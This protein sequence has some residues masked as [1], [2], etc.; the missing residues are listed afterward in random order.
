MQPAEDSA[1]GEPVSS[2]CKLYKLDGKS[3]EAVGVGHAWVNTTDGQPGG[4]L[5]LVDEDDTRRLLVSQTVEATSQEYLRQ[6]DVILFTHQTTQDEYGLSFEDPAGCTSVWNQLC[7][8]RGIATEEPAESPHVAEVTRLLGEGA[9]PP[10]ERGHLQ[11]LAEF[12]ENQFT[13]PVRDAI[14]GY[15]KGQGYLELLLELFDESETLEDIGNLHCIWRILRS[16]VLLNSN[17]LLSEMV[18]PASILRVIACFE[19]NPLRPNKRLN[20]RKFLSSV[21]FLNPAGLSGP[22]CERIRTIYL[23]QYLKDTVLAAVLDEPSFESIN[24]MVILLRNEALRV[25]ARSCTKDGVLNHI[26]TTIRD[27]AAEAEV[28]TQLLCFLDEIINAARWL[29]PQHRQGFLEHLIREA[30]IL[31]I[32]ALYIRDDSEKVR[33]AAAG[34]CRNIAVF[35]VNQVRQFSLAEAEA[36][37]PC[38]FLRMLFEQ[39]VHEE[40]EGL[41]HQ[42]ADVVRLIV[43]TQQQKQ[44][45]AQQVDPS[46]PEM[47]PE[48][49]RLLYEP[50]PPDDPKLPVIMD[51][52]FRPI[53]FHPLHAAV[54]DVPEIHRWIH[55]DPGRLARTLFCVMPVITSCL[56]G[57]KRM[58]SY[59]LQRHIPEKVVRILGSDKAAVSRDRLTVLWFVKSMVSV[60]N[61]V[62][63][64]YIA[65]QD[66]FSVVF[67]TLEHSSARA[68]CDLPASTCLSM[69]KEVWKDNEQTLLKYLAEK[70]SGLLLDQRCMFGTEVGEMIMKKHEANATRLRHV[71]ALA[72]WQAFVPKLKEKDDPY[73]DEPLSPGTKGYDEQVE[74]LTAQGQ[75]RPR[76]EGPDDPEPGTPK[77]ARIPDPIDTPSQPSADAEGD[78]PM[79]DGSA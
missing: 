51:T 7:V 11:R 72:D 79:A 25:I 27:F 26:F 75:K 5:M 16:M 46:I 3:W 73:F 23:L 49:L 20:H 31:R 69:L 17:E 62:L 57:H 64:R 52:L 19:Y 43:E 58:G 63:S 15:F 6:D 76:E 71:A 14:A 18:Q 60:H 45:Y 42:W 50:L 40:V 48:F 35:D 59:V 44:Q 55:D 34:I 56:Q 29:I 74:E 41:Q 47:P 37:E 67:Q 13:R 8:A 21:R 77:S 68:N 32:V 33:Q 70:Y 66:L 1:N 2:R 38:M 10:A 4:R 39:F 36:G 53:V 22:L 78:L 28:R 54:D 61:E 24:S 30:H 12:L 9:V 65:D